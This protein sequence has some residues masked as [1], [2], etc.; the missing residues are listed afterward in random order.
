MREKLS[1]RNSSSSNNGGKFRRTN[2]IRI[3]RKNLADIPIPLRRLISS[4]DHHTPNDD[5][6]EDLT[7]V[8]QI[9]RGVKLNPVTTRPVRQVNTILQKEKTVFEILVEALAKRNSVMQ[10]SSD[11]EDPD[12]DDGDDSDGVDHCEGNSTVG[13]FSGQQSQQTV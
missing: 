2:A 6:G 11:E 3:K 1:G 5:S 13:R 4:I 9:R 12:E 10:L 7:L 8:E